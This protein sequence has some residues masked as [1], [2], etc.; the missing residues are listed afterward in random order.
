M[1]GRQGDTL[2]PM[3]MSR[4]FIELMFYRAC[5]TLSY[6]VLAVTAGWHIYELTKDPLSLGLVGLAEVVPYFCSALFAGHAVDRQPKK[7][8]ALFGCSLHVLI[9]LLMVP[10]AL[11]HFSG[12][13]VGMYGLIY[14][15]VGLAGLARAFIRPT[16]QVLFAQVL[17]REDF[18]QGSAIGTVVYQAAQVI[19]PVVGG[20]LIAWP[21]LESAY[22]TSGVFA[23]L[24]MIAV[25][26]LRTSHEALAPSELSM[27]AGIVQGFRFVFSKQIMLAAMAL[28]MF[29]VLFG[30]A[31]A[32]LPAFIDEILQGSPESLGLLRAAPAIGSVLAGAWLARHPIQRH[33][34]RYLLIAVA[35]FGATV[36]GFGWSTSFWLAAFFLFWTGVFDGIS[37]VLRSTILQLM[38]PDQMRGRISAI[39]G[40][41]IGSSNEIGALE[42]GL[43]ASA[44]GLSTSI[45]FGGVVTLFVVLVCWFAAPKLRNLELSELHETAKTGH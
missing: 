1:A 7:R 19:G 40:I 10:V 35:G 43:A 34:G 24:A 2:L 3:K 25:A 32:M 36:I 29:A 39:N 18:A 14:V 9:A 33:G 38:T 42:S 31:V 26:L 6:Q 30:G 22:L 12:L 5:L 37:V 4:A 44:L 41:F 11:G 28:D 13:G 20:L 23:L 15:A 17:R 45:V 8:I 16:Y 27:W 21:G